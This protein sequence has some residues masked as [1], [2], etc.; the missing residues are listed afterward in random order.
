MRGGNP[1]GRYGRLCHAVAVAAAATAVLAARPLALAD[2]GY[3]CSTIP[4]GAQSALERSVKSL[5]R[6]HS[7]TLSDWQGQPVQLGGATECVG[8]VLADF[9][10]TGSQDVVALYRVGD[11]TDHTVLLSAFQ[12]S[13]Q[14]RGSVVEIVPGA[15]ALSVLPPGEYARDPA[16]TRELRPAEKAVLTSSRPGVTINLRSTSCLA[17]F[18]GDHRWVFTEKS[19]Q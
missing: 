12:S 17:F 2:A 8:A 19:C 15:R 13:S 11:A 9:D 5:L 3:S 6:E 18:L 14:W 7:A 1:M 16:L 4:R 10:G